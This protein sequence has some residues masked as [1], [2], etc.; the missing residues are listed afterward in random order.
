[1]GKIEGI[2]IE[3]YGSLKSICL[4]K[5]LSRQKNK[6]LSNLVTIIGPSGAGKSTIADAF[7]FIADCLEKGVE[8]ACDLNNRGGFERL[9]S[10]NANAPIRFEIYYKETNSSSPITYE[11]AINLDKKKRPF[12]QEER[13]R[14]RL[15]NKRYGRPRSFLNIT[16]GEGYAFIGNESGINEKGEIEGK[17]GDKVDV[18]LSDIRKLGVSTY[19]A[20]SEYTRIVDF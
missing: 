18:K 5:T 9:V 14:Q 6:P 13:L 17:D 1:M 10:Q 16:G 15:P 19:G 11:L 20:M 3:N 7:G 4:G 2:R 12:V 8:E